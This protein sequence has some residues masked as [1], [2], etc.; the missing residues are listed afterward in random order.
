MG[1]H[2]P[3]YELLFLLSD[4]NDL[5]SAAENY[6]HLFTLY[7]QLMNEINITYIL[8]NKLTYLTSNIEVS[9]HIFRE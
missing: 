3:E 8:F 2:K 1:D 4:V 6:E 5:Q 9:Y 7:F